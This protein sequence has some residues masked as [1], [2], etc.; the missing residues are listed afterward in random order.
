MSLKTT[1]TTISHDIQEQ[2]RKHQRKWPPSPQEVLD[3]V[4]H[5]HSD[6]LYNLI[7]WIVNPTSCYDENGIVKLSKTKAT[8]VSKICDDIESLIP[9]SCPSFSLILLS[10]QVYRKRESSVIAN[11]LH[12][13]GHGISHTETKFIEDKWAEWSE[14]TSNIVPA[15]IEQGVAVN[16]VVDNINWKNKILKEKRH[17]TQTQF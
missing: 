10:L 5:Y 13:F 11:D 8:K 14:S 9:N 15:N 1:A 2:N 3:D 17:T 4:R 6:S 12:K 7:A 16:D